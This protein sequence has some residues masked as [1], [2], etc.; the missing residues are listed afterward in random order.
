MT[1]TCGFITLENM[2]KKNFHNKKLNK[3][4]CMYVCVYF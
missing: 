4:V 3:Y 2:F 1:G